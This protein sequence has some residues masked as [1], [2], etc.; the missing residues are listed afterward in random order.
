MTQNATSTIRDYTRKMFP[1]VNKI[2]TI[3]IFG[4]CILKKFKFYWKYRY[5][6]QIQSP[7]VFSAYFGYARAVGFSTI[8][9]LNRKCWTKP[10]ERWVQNEEYITHAQ[11]KSELVTKHEYEMRLWKTNPPLLLPGPSSQEPGNWR[12]FYHRSTVVF[13]W[14]DEQT[15]II[16]YN[17]IK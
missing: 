13:T 14:I 1:L 6:E 12:S 2:I 5:H 3:D 11:R 10:L 4:K 17:G 7:V 9:S 15:S 8:Y 16:Y